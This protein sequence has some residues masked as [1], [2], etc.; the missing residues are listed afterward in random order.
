MKDFVLQ[1]WWKKSE[2]NS[3]YALK[4]NL[5]SIVNIDQYF[6]KNC[7]NHILKQEILSEKMSEEKSETFRINCLI[8]MFINRNLTNMS[9]KFILP[10]N[11]IIFE[12]IILTNVIFVTT[13]FKTIS[14]FLNILKMFIILN[15]IFAL[16]L[17]IQK[18]ITNL[19][20]WLLQNS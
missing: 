4:L 5:L 14:T 2:K 10:L 19:H 8:A 18:A 11:I 12:M 3:I 7:H 6:V 9:M 16:I 1:T 17:L 15:V 20:Q 13:V